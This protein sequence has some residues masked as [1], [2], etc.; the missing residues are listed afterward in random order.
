MQSGLT[1]DLLGPLNAVEQKFAPPTLWTEGDLTLLQRHPRIAV[2]GTRHP[3]PEGERRAR[4]LVKALV[5]DSAI[6]VS[7]LAQGI[8]TIGHTE[9]MARGGRTIAVIGT[10]LDDVFPKANAALQRRIGEAHLL[11]SQ[12][13]PSTPVA[14]GNFPRRNRTMALVADASVIIEAGEG[15][16]TLSHGWE[17]LRLGRP[18]FLLKSLLESGLT[19]PRE[20]LDHGALVL[21]AT[22][23]LLRVLPTGDVRK[24]VTL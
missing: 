20:M 5:A 16:G 12:F 19:W 13:A 18:L 14:R 1:V 8:D 23:D 6:I 2:V 7:G 3:S 22:E 11:V 24:A 9:A 21:A 4:K 15:S 17:A 10:P